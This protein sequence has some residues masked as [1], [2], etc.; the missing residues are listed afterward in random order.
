MEKMMSSKSIKM[1][2]DATFETESSLDAE[3][4]KTKEDFNPNYDSQESKE[5]NS[6]N[7]PNKKTEAYLSDSNNPSNL[8]KLATTKSHSNNYN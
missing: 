2:Q 7:S 8:S 3:Q 5:G 6:K 4:I 1:A